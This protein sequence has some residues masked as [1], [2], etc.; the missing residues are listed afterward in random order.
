MN[1]I[2]RPLIC[3]F[4]VFLA[5]LVVQAQSSLTQTFTAS[6]GSFSIMY[7]DAWTVN[8]QPN[9]T[10]FTT[11]TLPAKLSDPFQPGQ[12]F[13]NINSPSA[14]ADAGVKG[15]NLHD[16]VT[17]F[18]TVLNLSLSL[19]DL[20]IGGYSA[21]RAV[22]NDAN[23]DGLVF[24]IDIGGHKTL[25]T[26]KTAKGELAKL[27]A[28]MQAMI[29]TLQIG[30][31]IGNAP[32][33]LSPTAAATS[34][35]NTT[36]SLTAGAAANGTTL[37][38]I[39]GTG[40]GPSG[41][42]NELYSLSTDGKTG[43]SLQKFGTKLSSSFNQVAWSPDGTRLLYYSV[44]PPGL[45]ST[46]ADGGDVQSF[47]LPALVYDWAPDGKTIT[48][49]AGDSSDWQFLNVN[50]DMS[51]MK[52]VLSVKG[53]GVDYIDYIRWSTDGKWLAYVGTPT[54]TSNEEIH[55]IDS[56]GKND[57]VIVPAGDIAR[58]VMWSADNTQIAYIGK[59]GDAGKGLITVDI[60]T[61]T[62]TVVAK[63]AVAADWSP[64][65]T[66]FVYA[67][68]DGKLY[69]VGVDGK[70]PTELKLPADVKGQIV[71]IAWQPKTSS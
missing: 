30:A 71:A 7:P 6:D 35:A 31:S 8:A 24:G 56:T 55:I 53:S 48:T 1:K 20:T 54:G 40:A 64:D 15:D 67:S 59:S 9:F 26:G 3:I 68:S 12:M 60:A 45:V 22:N 37:A 14:L 21:V 2:L 46:D 17:S 11:A 18:L 34:A 5:T 47:V 32:T 44:N 50:A 62:K 38:I 41:L 65:G 49:G 69:I 66:Q 33:Q 39:F 27:D 57:Q 70:K 16:F 61:K 19:E 25:M 36:M 51:D 4:V 43:K 13:V 63:D 42:G 10:R 58:Y 23:A 28:T 52:P 29:A